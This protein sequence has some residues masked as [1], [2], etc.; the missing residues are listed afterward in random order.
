LLLSTDR[1]AGAADAASTGTVRAIRYPNPNRV[2]ID[3]IDTTGGYLVL[4]DVDYPGWRAAI[5]GRVAPI[6]TAY[7]HFRAVQL[8]RDARQV[9]FE[10]AP[11]NWWSLVV[12]G[13]A[14][15]C[16]ISGVIVLDWLRRPRA[17][18]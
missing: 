4:T 17:T 7:G 18:R 13:A 1:A 9:V 12:V 8:T 3:L 10:F 2:E 5:D 6:M 15:W 14:C 16:A 11:S